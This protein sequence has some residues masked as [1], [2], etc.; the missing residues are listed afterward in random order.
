M[1]PTGAEFVRA[2]IGD[3]IVDRRTDETEDTFMARA[4]AEALAAT[5]KRPSRVI[6]LPEE[7]L[8]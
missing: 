7:A 1:S 5:R 6:L 3:A 2:R 4:K 8:P